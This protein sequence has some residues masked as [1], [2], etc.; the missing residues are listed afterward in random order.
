ME[1]RS[2]QSIAVLYLLFVVSLVALT[3]IYT[4]KVDKKNDEIE[5]I[6]LEMDT[7]SEQLEKAAQD[8]T[9]HERTSTPD[10]DSDLVQRVHDAIRIKR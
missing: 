5:R 10:N 4:Y 6:L 2:N 8:I 3:I 9:P 7:L 1:W